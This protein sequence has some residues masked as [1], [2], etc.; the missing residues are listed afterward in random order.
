M[1]HAMS[2]AAS[3]PSNRA[4]ERAGLGSLIIVGGGAVGTSLAWRASQ[5]G[6]K[7]TVVDEAPDLGG[8]TRMQ[9]LDVDGQQVE[10]DRFY[11][12]VLESDTRVKGLL[13]ELG[14]ADGVRWTAAP[15]AIVAQG[16]QYPA[17]SLVDMAMLPALK[18]TDRARI[19]ASIA[20][21]L[22]LPLRLAN[23]MTSA[24]WIRRAAGQSAYDS[25]WL[26]ILR[27]KLG[28]QADRV[29]ASFLVSTFRRLVQARLQGAGDKFG[30]LP[31]GY[32][33]VF[34][35]L[36]QRVQD[37]GGE[38]RS[39]VR[40]ERIETRP[41]SEG[42][43]VRVHLSDGTALDAD[44]V[45]VTT[46]APIVEKLVP[47]LTDAER[48]QL[49]QS[50]YLGVVCGTFLLATPPNDSYITY[51][52]DD[53]DL[54][55]VIGMHALLPAEFTGGAS[56]V[57]LPH[58]CGSDD[59]WFGLGDDEVRERMLAGLKQAFPDFEPDVRAWAINRA[60]FVVPLP[61]PHAGSPLPFATSVPGVH[62]VGTAQNTTGTLNVEQSLEMV[63]KALPGI[64]G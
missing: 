1:V 60:P 11:H 51:L 29:S 46:P 34:E 18:A 12:V 52:V 24:S 9:N 61:V 4:R 47:Q 49:S 27:A 41:A 42:A 48:A 55:G 31:H 8:L 63:D 57:Y 20:A 44:D 5:K 6:A 62:V 16:R 30:V 36:R 22:A 53:V 28:T 59:E 37:A 54:T 26:P 50:P 35:Q 58:Y 33:P 43:R 2:E 17:T 45:V 39:G 64:L 15:A 21:S 25:F 56:L 14:M 19:G 3:T 32:G 38:F 7:V 23:R 10:V 40:V 13:D